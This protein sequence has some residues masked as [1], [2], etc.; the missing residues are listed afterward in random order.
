MAHDDPP[1]APPLAPNDHAREAAEVLLCTAFLLAVPTL[2]ERQLAWIRQM[3]AMQQPATKEYID[4][5]WPQ[6]VREA[7]L[8]PD[9]PS[10]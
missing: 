5:N 4:R 10:T 2:P 1:A 6:S 8:G 7:L 9:R 3:T